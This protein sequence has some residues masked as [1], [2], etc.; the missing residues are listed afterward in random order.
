MRTPRSVP[1]RLLPRGW[2]LPALTYLSSRSFPIIGLL[3]V[4]GPVAA[5]LAPGRAFTFAQ[6]TSWFVAFVSGLTLAKGIISAD[7]SHSLWMVLFQLPTTPNRYYARKIL[8]A[9]V[10]LTVFALVLGLL[11]AAGIVVQDGYMPGLGA[12]VLNIVAWTLV[13]FLACT[14]VSGWVRNGDLEITILIFV[15]TFVQ[16]FIAERLELSRAA[17]AVV[18]FLLPPVDAL[19]ALGSGIVSGSLDLRPEWI[20]QLIFYPVATITLALLGVRRLA[21]TDVDRI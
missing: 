21:R 16:A 9:L 1:A 13:V 8:I 18:S 15:F 19:S 6:T 14:A 2:H 3:L 12:I 17:R 10:V 4:A 11:T 5:M 20:A 7:R